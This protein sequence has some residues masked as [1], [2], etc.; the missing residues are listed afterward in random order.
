MWLCEYNLRTIELLFFSI[1]HIIV[2]LGRFHLL[3]LIMESCIC[4]ACWSVS[5]IFWWLLLWQQLLTSLSLSSLSSYRK[6]ET[7]SGKL[8]TVKHT[9]ILFTQFLLLWQERVAFRGS[10][11][12]IAY[13]ASDL[14]KYPT[15]SYNDSCDAKV[16][17]LRNIIHYDRYFT[18]KQLSLLC[19]LNMKPHVVI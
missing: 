8:V 7:E 14:L 17:S 10:Y 16:P 9:H 5:E 19:G 15:T 2:I 12:N 1:F 11:S 6:A 4:E 3:W 18:I 13:N